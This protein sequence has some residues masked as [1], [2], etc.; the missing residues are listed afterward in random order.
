MFESEVFFWIIAVLAFSVII[1]VHELGHFLAAKRAGVKVLEFGLGYPPR[2]FG[3]KIRETI[4]SINLIP[5]GGFLRMQDEDI[6]GK[7]KKDSVNYNNKS[8]WKR[9]Q[10]SVAGVLFNFIFA[11]VALTIGFSIGI[12]PLIVEYDDVLDAYY[13]G[14][15]NVEHGFKVEEV[16]E[17]SLASEAGILE[18]DIILNINDSSYAELAVTDWTKEESSFNAITYLRDNKQLTYKSG[19][20]F[21][22]KDLGL[23]IKNPG[24]LPRMKLFKAY[25]GLNIGD[26]IYDVNGEKILVYDDLIRADKLQQIDEIQVYRDGAFET[27][28]V[29]LLLD[30]KIV[31]KSNYRLFIED[32]TDDSP[33]KV[34]G[35]VQNDE[36]ISVNGKSVSSVIELRDEAALNI[37]KQIEIIIRRDGEQIA[38]QLAINDDGIIGVYLMPVVNA[39]D[40]LFLQEFFEEV[41]I[42]DIGKVKYPVHK[43]FY[44]SSS[45]VLR[46]GVFSVK[47][48]GQVV[49]QLVS[50]FTVP[51]T[52]AGPVGIAKMSVSFAKEGLLSLLRFIAVLSLSLGVLNLLPIP[53]LD[54]GKLVFLIIEGVFRRRV[55]PKVENVIHMLGFFLLIVMLLF[56]T[57]NDIIK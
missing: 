25:Q 49:S 30:S 47:M 55:S 29:D 42:I 18:G 3:K 44:H 28:S 32:F 17:S 48:F 22:F 20:N 40:D 4:Y 54:G 45:E 16:S 39:G 57:Y 38:K 13:E 2:V 24:Q 8:V 33:A 56:V 51:E 50:K 21:E 37:G 10:I 34:A 35:F 12:E 27:L 23:V 7:D 5:F 19:D 11:L 9:M 14:A 26:I 1:I 31:D 52:V 41:S 43:A 53:A 15:L 6:S 36:I 46:L